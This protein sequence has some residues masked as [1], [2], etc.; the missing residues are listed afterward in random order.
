MDA[1]DARSVG[2]LL[3]E[4]RNRALLTQEQLAERAGL[5]VRTIRRLE[6]GD[7]GGRPHG[8]S[9]QLLAAALHLGEEDRATLAAAVGGVPDRTADPGGP[10]APDGWA[11][12]RQLPSDVHGF[13]GRD[14]DVARLDKIM[15]GL[16]GGDSAPVVISAI[17]GTAGIG[18]TALAV[19]WAHHAREHFPD[20]QLYVDLRGYGPGEPVRPDDALAAMLRSAGVAADRVPAGMDERSA[21][22][23]STLAT[24]RVLILLDN[25]RDSDQ[26]RPLL[27][28][29]A[30][31]V[32]VTSRRRLRALSVHHGARQVTLDVLPERDAVELLAE[33]IGRQR[34]ESEP[35][36]AS[37]IVRLCAR[38][39]LALRLA[40]ER[41]ADTPG[42][43]LRELAAELADHRGRLA[44]LSIDES[45]DTDLRSVFTWS[46]DALDPE[47]ARMF[48]VLGLHPGNG[49]SVPAAAALAGVPPVEAAA[50]LRRLRNA[51]MLEERFPGRFELHDL[52]REYACARVEQDP[53]LCSAARGRLLRWYAH[54]A[55]DARARLVA[56]PHELPIPPGPPEGITPE[57]FDDD[58]AAAEW[59]DAEQDAIVEI[60][61][62]ADDHGQ[63]EAAAVL[64][65]LTWP[66]FYVRGLWHQMRVVGE[67]GVEHAVA[68]GDA[69]LEAKIRNGLSQPYGH[70]PGYAD[71][72]IETSRAALAIFERLGIRRGQAACLLNLGSAYHEANRLVEA[73][74]AHERARDL[75]LEE[76]NQLYAA[77][78]L[79]NLAGAL[80]ELGL[81]DEA[82]GHARRA[83][84][85]IRDGPEPFRVVPALV[86]LA[87]VH[88]ARGDHDA[89]VRSYREAVAA[90]DR[91][92]VR[93]EAVPVRI[94]LGR[95][96]A[97]AGADGEATEVWREAHR[98]AVAH[99]DPR[100]EEIESLLAEVRRTPSPAPPSSPA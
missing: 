96:L 23:R 8:T 65:Q 16:G 7:S 64:G 59:I 36:A 85:V 49:V 22:L 43:P 26:V 5:S 88:A 62:W 93:Y 95:Q 89:A 2:S 48:E 1:G 78:A 84:E 79:N 10:P 51:S 76:G 25:A 83:V 99:G 3:R 15:G 19:H 44:A 29:S 21:L 73:R 90:A 69:L 68:I 71:A 32:L 30:A 13:I 100:V 4:W 98:I 11:P 31:V 34:V 75:Y 41:A 92:D 14:D 87:G 20:G 47:A 46:Y 66:H 27:P 61:R 38:L 39:P 70:L 56:T 58:R 67:A 91:L 50:A 12:P 57:R 28:G 77:F 97:A 80:V 24:R 17:D 9:L 35:E 52:L 81:H 42:R 55:E 60:V 40:A 33:A 18:K 86:T 37:A 63:R 94:K 74:E 82:L 53:G 72:E 6:S 45:P 54:T